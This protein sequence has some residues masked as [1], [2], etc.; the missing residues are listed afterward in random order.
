MNDKHGAGMEPC[1]RGADKPEPTCTNRHQCWEPCGELGKSEEYVRVGRTDPAKSAAAGVAVR[2]LPTDA[3]GEAVTPQR[4]IAW[5]DAKF[6]RHGDEEDK[7][8]ADYIRAALGVS[9][10]DGEV[11]SPKGTDDSEDEK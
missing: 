5:L 4:L 11:V 9:M 6:K 8:A 2:Q 3:D 1:P 10:L 7:W